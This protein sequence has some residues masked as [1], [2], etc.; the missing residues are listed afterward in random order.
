[1]RPYFQTRRRSERGYVLLVLLL[2]VAF[3][4]IASLKMVEDFNYQS[5]R[6]REEEMIHRGCE[7]T[8][9]VKKY[10]KKFGRYPTRIEDLESTNRL[11]FVRKRYQDPMNRDPAAGKE[12]G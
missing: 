10:F 9:A 11:R 6:D 1:M 3:L 7:Y 8:R 12:R 5:K 2:L 4:S